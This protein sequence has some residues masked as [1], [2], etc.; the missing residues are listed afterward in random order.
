[1][2]AVQ[3][4]RATIGGVE[5]AE[6]A[7]MASTD[8]GVVA[9]E[10]IEKLEDVTIDLPAS[11]TTTVAR[12][13]RGPREP[14]AAL[15]G[16][17]DCNDCC[18]ACDSTYKWYELKGKG[19]CCILLLLLFRLVV[20]IILLP[21]AILLCVLCACVSGKDSTAHVDFPSFC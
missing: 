21:F 14:R 6:K 17:W 16:I 5:L 10:T 2:P 3:E 19:Y 9:T 20:G 4:E 8:K 18:C 11:V 7:M 12:S 13:F 1:M 15:P